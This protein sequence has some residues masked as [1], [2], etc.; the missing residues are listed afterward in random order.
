MDD[1]I[2]QNLYAPPKYDSVPL[3]K[4]RYI[5]YDVI[6]SNRELKACARK[7]LQGVW[8]Q[9]ASAFFVYHAILM[10]PA[11]IFSE[12]SPL[13]IP[14]ID[15]VGSI[16]VNIVSG[17][18]ALGF[19]G[20]FLKRIRD[21]DIALQNIFEGFKRFVPSFL[22]A[23]FMG[24]FILLWSFLLLIPGIIKAFGYSMAYYI[25]HDNPE[26]KPLEALNKSQIMM[27]GY[28]WK[29]FTLYF[30]FFGWVL[31]GLFTLGIGYLWLNPYIQLSV[32]NF[33]E[34]LKEVQGKSLEE[35]GI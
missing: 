5:D 18:F 34:N 16:A 7:Q 22:V 4:R 31:L 6:Q 25:M 28:K 21:E 35:D 30:S 24:L 23:F 12:I 32:T 8:G 27:K 1:N 19:A 10:V 26:I 14:V 20:Y 3:E 33:Y 11:L 17:P 13:R 9:M 29:L 2:E 15:R